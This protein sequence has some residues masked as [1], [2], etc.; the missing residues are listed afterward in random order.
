MRSWGIVGGAWGDGGGRCMA[1]PDGPIRRVGPGSGRARLM[2]MAATPPAADPHRPPPHVQSWQI[3]RSAGPAGAFHHRAVPSPVEPAAWIHQVR[4]PALVLGSAQPDSVVDTATAAGDRV[5]VTRRRS[6]GGLVSLVPGNDCWIDLIIP[7]QSSLWVE[8]VGR[9]FHWV[10]SVWAD[11][12]TAVLPPDLAA[13][14]AV[15]TGPP[16]GREA[17]RVVCFAGLGPGEVT[18]AGRKVVGLSLRRWRD[19]AR[20]QCAM[21]WRWSG[22]ILA[23][24]LSAEARATLEGVTH[25]DVTRLPAGLPDLHRAPDPTEVVDAVLMRLPDPGPACPAGFEPMISA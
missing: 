13:T 18:V 7:R 23:R 9:A 2:V 3:L 22:D 6:G 24:Y 8:D 17:G 14:V 4:A 25:C 19:G 16:L 1:A 15:Y 20:F 10:G 12:L 21:T 11:A 5:E